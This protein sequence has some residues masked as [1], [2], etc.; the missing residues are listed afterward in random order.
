MKKKL[1]FCEAIEKSTVEVLKSSKR[2]LLF[3]LEVTNEGTPYVKARKKQVFETPVSELSA[4]GLVVGLSTQNFNPTIVYGR[5]EFALLA[6][7]QIFTQASRWNYMF[8]K[9]S[10]CNANFRIQIGR[11]WGNGPQHTANYHSI[12]LQSVGM[13]IY[14]PSTPEEAFFQIKD[15][16]KSE[17]PCVMLEHRY[18]NQIS[19]EFEVNKKNYK[20]KNYN[21]FKEK[22]K[23]NIILVTYADTFYDALQARQFLRNYDIDIAILNLSYFPSEKRLSDKVLNIL[24]EYQSNIFIESAPKEFSLLSGVLSEKILKNINRKSKNYFLSPIN[25]PAPAYPKGISSYYINKND[26]IYKVLK[27]LN[28]NLKLKKLSFEESVLWPHIYINDLI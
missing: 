8:N 1:R 28:K 6:F 26:I 16:N 19:Q 27:I 7:D 23:S 20:I 25:V 15:M 9:K 22:K 4:T 10:V 12:F 11:Q 21:F 17:K 18:L 14:I 24:N 2:N 5:V 3:G 13:D